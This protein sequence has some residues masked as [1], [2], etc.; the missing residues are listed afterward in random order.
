M[1][2]VIK[3]QFVDHGIENASYFQGCGVA[4]TEYDTCFTG[5]GISAISAIEDCL[6]QAA[7]MGYK[8]DKELE[9]DALDDTEF[10]DDSV[11][12]NDDDSD[13]ELYYHV[14]VRLKV[15]G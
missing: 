14:S 2:K 11:P 10:S 5:I 12:D 7:C 6:E 3:M 8:I 15:K 1:H 9:Q 13:N 4:L